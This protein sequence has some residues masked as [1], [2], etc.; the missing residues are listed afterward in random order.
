MTRKQALI[1]L[2][3][4]VKAGDVKASHVASAF[5][6][7]GINSP[8]FTVRNICEGNSL[9]AAKALRIALGLP[10]PEKMHSDARLEL[11]DILEALIAQEASE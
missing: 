9:D 2:R 4:K 6:E 3:D 10:V 1:E 8:Y 7:K 5:P 11:L